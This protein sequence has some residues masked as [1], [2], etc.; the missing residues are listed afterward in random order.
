MQVSPNGLPVRP[1]AGYRSP[2]TN[3]TFNIDFDATALVEQLNSLQVR[4][5]PFARAMAATKLA[6]DARDDLREELPA[7]FRLTS[8]WLQRGITVDKATKSRPVAM[9]FSRDEYMADH[10]TGALRK[11]RKKA[12]AVPTKQVKRTGKGKIGK[13]NRPAALL[14]K[15]NV[16]IKSRSDDL[17][18][19]VR[20]T[21]K[22][23]RVLYKLQPQVG[24]KKTWDFQGTATKAV[25]TNQVKRLNEALAHA[26]R[27]SRKG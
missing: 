17:S 26:V 8:K 9:V 23:L 24:I 4:E 2:M 1:F 14:A 18:F 12:I 21:G 7:K 6:Y 3:D 16:F 27:T 22:A 25:R 20:R 13:A 5:W 15:R 11:P 10:V 19:I